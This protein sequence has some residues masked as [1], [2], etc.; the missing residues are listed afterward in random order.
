[1]VD[2]SIKNVG[3]I[4]I[5][6]TSAIN[7]ISVSGL[8]VVLEDIVST[9]RTLAYSPYLLKELASDTAHLEVSCRELS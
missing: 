7:K 2:V 8:Q 3:E 9:G 1:M 6:D 5:L 4:V